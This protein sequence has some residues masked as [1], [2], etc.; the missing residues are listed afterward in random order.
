MKTI[1]T[2]C[3]AFLMVLGSAT[4]EA[5]NAKKQVSNKTASNK[6][7]VYYFHF[8]RRC[9]TCMA[10]E[11][12]AKKT[13]ESLYPQ[14]IKKGEITFKSMNLDEKNSEV[15]AK[16]CEAAGQSLLIISGKK[17]TDLTMQGFMYARS[18]PDKLKQEIKK[19][20]D[21]LLSSK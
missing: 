3:F 8:T 6:I 12:E 4:C 11:S 10:V 19:V 15:A 2:I 16:K 20:I 17:K 21:P 14:Q 13:L 9:M 18:N 5:K 1:L 7:E